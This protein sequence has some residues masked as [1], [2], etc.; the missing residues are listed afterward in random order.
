MS[1]NYAQGTNV[2][3][4]TTFEL[5]EF[6]E[7]RIR[8][9]M[10]TLKDVLLFVLFSKPGSYP[11]IPQIGMNIEDQLY[12]FYDEI[13]EDNIKSNIIDQC[14]LLG[15]YISDGTI[16][17]KKAIYRNKP[18]L[19]IQITGTEHFPAGYKHDN[20]N[21]TDRFYIGITYD[22]LNKMIY[23]VNAVSS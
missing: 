15:T 2:G 22:E 9:Q 4:D 10:E 5:N 1:A 3:Y 12:S 7:P 17:I 20:I 16:Q 6:N 11:S 8:S 19:I 21:D 13:N 23:N 18:S 14:S